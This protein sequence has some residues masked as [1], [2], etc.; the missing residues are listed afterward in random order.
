[1]PLKVKKRTKFCDRYLAIAEASGP[2]ASIC[3]PSHM[4]RS[5][6]LALA[7]VKLVLQKNASSL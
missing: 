1:M 4:G 7:V 3:V 6:Q 5:P 2:R